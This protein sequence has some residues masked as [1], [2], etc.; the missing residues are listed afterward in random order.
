MR[1]ASIYRR[2]SI[3]VSL[4][5]ACSAVAFT[6]GLAFAQ[7]TEQGYRQ[8]AQVLVDIV[9]A[10]PTPAVRMSPDDEWMLLLERPSLPPIADLAARELRLAGTRIAPR[11]NGRSRRTPYTG[12]RFM[13]IADRREVVVTGLPANPKL[14]DVEWSP[15]GK[16]V[17]FTQTANDGIELWVAD[18]ETG[19]ARRLTGPV[20]NTV[21]AGGP[22]WVADSWTI[23]VTMIPEARGTEPAET[24]V[25]SGP[26]IQQNVDKTA[27][28]RTYQDLLENRHDEALFEHYGTAQL[29]RITV[30]GKVTRLGDPG[31]IG[32]FSPSP[33]GRYV[34]VERTHRPFSY[35]VPWYRFP[36]RIEVLD[37]N[38]YPVYLIADLPLQEEVPVPFG[39][40]PTGP[41][42]VSWRADAPATLYW[43]EALDGGDAGKPA[44]QRDRVVVHAAP[45][46]NTPEPVITL[47]Y[48][49]GGIMWGSDDLALVTERW[50]RTR[51]ARVWRVRPNSLES[52][53]EL[54]FDR[55]Y[56]DR[57]NDPGMPVMRMNARGR[58]VLRTT[59]RG[60][61]LFLRGQG[62]SPEGDRPFIDKFDLRSK[63]TQRLF[64]SEA[65]VYEVPLE[66]LDDQARTI[67]TSRESQEEPPNYFIRDLRRGG[68]N[69]LT[70]FLNPTRQLE[71]MQ[72]EL[73]QYQR[74]DGVTLSG[75]LYLPPG[76]DA[77]R[78]GP[79]PLFVWAYPRE[80]KDPDA[81]AQVVGSPYRY[82]RLG[83]WSTPIWVAL[84]YAV[85][86]G[87]T[88]PIVGEGDAEPND[89][90]VE[91]LVASAEAATVEMERRG[92]AERGRMGI[93]GHSYGAFMAANVL[94][95][96]DV[97]SAGIA[98]SGAYNRSLT[99]F[100]FQAE[101][102]T[103]WEAP[104]VYFRMSPFM[105]ADKINEPILLI[106]GEADNNSG[107]FP[108]QSERYYHALKG[109]G[110][111]AR[112]VL[113]PHESHGYRARE[114]IL[115]MLWEMQE[116]LERYV[117]QGP[118]E[119]KKVSTGR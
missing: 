95:H 42:N 64:R 24:R 49:Y 69:Q 110:K 51:Q 84:G 108:I 58:Y 27:P 73:I 111:T 39:S 99:P 66:V 102:R 113:L 76:Y 45:F 67:L 82:T 48:R 15:D 14:E 116:W 6:E 78:D 32:S 104:E 55:S 12:A 47:G 94:A 70:F 8:P 16:R 61:A 10:P 11:T 80:F 74:A 30:D 106:H 105:N 72:K 118:P 33:D 2:S 22:V 40:V 117:K 19:Q 112:L 103:F 17:A 50:W 28:A 71:G 26:T 46:A 20:L 97:F 1:V 91:Q 101:Q 114:S 83:G 87:A 115:H 85:L 81:A 89:T 41:R 37:M 4:L 93:G 119:G 56:E 21:L 9:D 59:D 90:Y 109:L 107:T 23:L 88:M 35:L 98:R 36:N 44:E 43:V 18:I 77:Q 29:V 5:A 31:L 25:P 62:A 53:P 54:I 7:G 34:L 65:P 57:Y 68:V 38:G 75:T 86:D 63:Q 60:R 79:L 13:R 3:G 52:E 92:I 100:G 96:S